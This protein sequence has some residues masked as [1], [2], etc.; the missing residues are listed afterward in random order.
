MCT[1]SVIEIEWQECV[2]I[3][4]SPHGPSPQYNGPSMRMRVR[5]RQAELMMQLDGVALGEA[6][7]QKPHLHPYTCSVYTYAVMHQYNK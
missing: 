7:I 4:V 5:A 3:H 2:L 6:P 1:E